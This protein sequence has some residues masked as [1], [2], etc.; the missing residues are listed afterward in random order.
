LA[1]AGLKMVRADEHL[2]VL[3]RDVRRFKKSGGSR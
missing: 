2:E 3:V 1:S